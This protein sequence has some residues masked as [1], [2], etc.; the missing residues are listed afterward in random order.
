MAKEVDHDASEETARA[1]PPL[2]AP[3]PIDATPG[4]LA[5]AFLK[6]PPDHE[7]QYPKNHK[8]EGGGQV[9]APRTL[10]S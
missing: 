4:E 3:E 5:E 6:V 7:W 1:L 9:A 2:P 8:K 10:C